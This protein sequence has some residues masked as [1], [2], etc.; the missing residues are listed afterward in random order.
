[1][2]F[3]PVLALGLLGSFS[4]QEAQ[5]I[6]QQANQEFA[7]QNYISAK[8]GYQKLLD[9][10]F[11]EA[12]LHYNLGTTCLELKELGCAIW[13]LEKANQ[14][15]P[16]S[17]D[18][19][20]NLAWARTEQLDS[21]PSVETPFFY[22]VLR[23][24]PNPFLAWALLGL[25]WALFLSFF[26]LQRFPKQLRLLKAMDFM[27][28]VLLGLCTFT[29]VAKWHAP[30]QW[31]EAIVLPQTAA[32]LQLPTKQAQP[33][34]ELHAGLKVRILERTGQF[35]KIRTANGQEAWISLQALGLL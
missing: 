8:N 4:P 26:C 11:V 18:I 10:G 3:L 35:A 22:R 24:I 6:F 1:M 19:H 7:A 2:T 33:L 27:L 16:N 21:V 9:A 23:N 5:S 15:S 14:L 32:T 30:S 12:E 25:A 13:N 17:E 31:E 20:F 34:F 28:W 29:F